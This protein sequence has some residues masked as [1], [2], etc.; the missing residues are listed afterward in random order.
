MFSEVS[1][2]LSVMGWGSHVTITHDALDFTVQGPIPQA[3]A[4][5]PDMGPALF[6]MLVISDGTTDLFKL[7]HLIYPPLPTSGV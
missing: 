2:S 7:V 5:P 1:V 4:P 6:S 3:P